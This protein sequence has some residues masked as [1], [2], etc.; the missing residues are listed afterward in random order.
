MEPAKQPRNPNDLLIFQNT[1][2][3]D[4]EWQFDAIRTPLPYFIAAGE[5]RELPFYIAKHGVEKLIDRI[6]QKKGL[7]HMNLLHR[8]NERDKI[9]LG[10]K[11][12][13]N[14]RPP[15]PNE[16]ALQAMQ[17]AKD[18]DPYEALFKERELAAE[19]KAQQEIAAAAPKAPLYKT[20]GAVPQAATPGQPTQT[21]PQPT[22]VG[23]EEAMKTV[24]PARL[25]I[26]NFLQNRAHMDI[27]HEK[28]REKL[29]SMTIP[30]IQAEFGEEFP[31]IIDPNRAPVAD[32]KESLSEAGMPT[33]PAG[34]PVV[35]TTPPQP[36]VAV[37]PVDPN[38]APA[39]PMP[40]AQPA[41]T[42]TPQPAPVAQPA[43]TIPVATAQPAPVRP[44]IP[45]NPQAPAA[46]LLDEQLQ[47]VR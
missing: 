34:N 14:M 30:E 33:T 15:T 26:Y 41:V 1:D 45:M 10:I 31:D 36:Q 12:I 24:D 4:F 23:N 39:N 38:P 42:P 16:L 35:P 28:T 9:V 5:T 40:A 20:Y 32:T 18:A 6:L 11:Q 29:D 22:H 43:P 3:E 25:A 47:Q 27:S 37:P 2:N 13:N 44:Q 17:K 46:P 21:V 7:N 8:K 19:Q